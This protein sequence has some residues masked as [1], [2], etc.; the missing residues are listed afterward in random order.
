MFAVETMN[1]ED[2]KV[3]D[4]LPLSSARLDIKS[5]RECFNKST[6]R[7][8]LDANGSFGFF[9]GVSCGFI[10]GVVQLSFQLKR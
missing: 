4:T 9:Y 8:V 10:Q 1:A 3:G 5:R 6:L 2:A 7:D